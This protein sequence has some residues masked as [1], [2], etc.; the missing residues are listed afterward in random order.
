M[1]VTL[2]R[3]DDFLS[4]ADAAKLVGRDPGTIRKWRSLGY[5]A[6]QGLDERGYPVHSPEAVRDAEKRVRESGLRS[7]TG[8]DPRRQCKAA[9][10]A[11]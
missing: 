6:A 2:P 10:E 7:A 9:R 4:T 3:A 5:L 8:A 11:A 1:V